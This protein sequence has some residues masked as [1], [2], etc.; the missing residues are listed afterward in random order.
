MDLFETVAVEKILSVVQRGRIDLDDAGTGEELLV[1]RPLAEKKGI[2]FALD[3]CRL[4][5]L[6]RGVP[7]FLQ[8]CC[9]CLTI[10]GQFGQTRVMR[11]VWRTFAGRR[12]ASQ[13]FDLSLTSLA[14]D[15]FCV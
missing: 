15:A 2:G 9:C 14:A 13:L 4:D 12:G 1:T 3:T 6:P 8:C 11:C 7:M 5:I 10:E